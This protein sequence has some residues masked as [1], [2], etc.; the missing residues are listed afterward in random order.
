MSFLKKVFRK[1]RK[2]VEHEEGEEEEVIPV[3]EEEYARALPREAILTV[4]RFVMRDSS[5]VDVI[6]AEVRDGNI[7]I[8]D[9]TPLAEKDPYEFRNAIKQLQTL[10][11]SFG[12]DIVK[13]NPQKLPLLMVTPSW[14]S[15]WK[16]GKAI[17]E[18]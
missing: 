3:L 18:G 2:P 8:I 16:M 14:V 5:D 15:V 7:L 13:I 12:G 6:V 10:V 1:E 9:I 4:K 11:K 17:R